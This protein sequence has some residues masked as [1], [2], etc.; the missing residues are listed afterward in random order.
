LTPSEIE[1]ATFRFVAQCLNLGERI[2]LKWILKKYDRVWL[3]KGQDVS[4]C[5]NGNKGLDH[6][7]AGEDLFEGG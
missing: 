4:S 1:L 2:I 6:K 7:V 5:Q 3:G